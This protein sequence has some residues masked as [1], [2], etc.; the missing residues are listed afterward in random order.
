MAVTGVFAA[1]FSSFF[2]AVEQADAKLQNLA[3]DAAHT[4]DA[5]AR[6]GE[7]FRGDAAAAELDKVDA[8]AKRADDD[9]GKLGSSGKT[10]VDTLTS[11]IKDLALGLVSLQTLQWAAGFVSG[12]AESASALADLSAQTR[13]SAEDLQVMQQAMGEFGVSG[14]ELGK[15]LF[16]L[17]VNIGK[18]D[19]SV[20]GALHAMG[21]SLEEVRNKNGVELFT[22]IQDGLAGLNGELRD[23]TA[24]TIYGEKLGRVMS[25][26][27]EGATEAIN[28]TRDLNNVMSNETVAALDQASEAV[29]RFKN[30]I[31]AI[32]AN[33]LGP[34]AAGWNDLFDKFEKGATTGQI[35]GARLKDLWGEL[36]TGQ[37]HVENMT[38]LF[39]NL[40]QQY[41]AAHPKIQAVTKAHE[42]FIGP[43]QSAADVA[44]QLAREHKA[45]A[46]AAKDAEQADRERMKQLQANASLEQ[47]IVS[48]NAAFK[49]QAVKEDQAAKAEQAKAEAAEQAQA[50][51]QLQAEQEAIDQEIA[52]LQ[53]VQAAS[54]DAGEAGATAGK[55]TAAGFER[56]TTSI[57]IS[58]DAIEK[59]MDLMDQTNRANAILSTG[60]FTTRSQLEQ[61]ANLRGDPRFG[62]GGGF[63]VPLSLRPGDLP[64]AGMS[65][66]N[67]FNLTDT[68][69]ALAQRISD[70]IMRTIR[71]GTQLGQT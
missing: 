20:A 61:I 45:D 52:G 57:N 54:T 55:Q 65:I 51:K 40:N 11:S 48:E 62:G 12:M 4:G 18:G 60:L 10:S 33:T 31:A 17:S 63:G 6:T 21:L 28:K 3:T 24:V 25:G 23:T 70:Q 37:P 14:D 47:K 67:N 43:T 22:T 71:S 7:S 68:E 44:A 16:K 32:G 13:I 30:H 19:D 36:T 8:A 39:D 56:A 5:L 35:V 41:D 50:E 27:A 2:D 53:K 64:S 26:A 46:A 1:D 15:A 38:R 34:V 66:T 49:K 59:W 58:A 42:E 69:S 9:L 29:D